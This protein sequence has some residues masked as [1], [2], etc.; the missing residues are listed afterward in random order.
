MRVQSDGFTN[1]EEEI[2]YWRIRMGGSID[3]KIPNGNS[4]D[5]KRSRRSRGLVRFSV[6][7]DVNAVPNKRSSAFWLVSSV[8]VLLIASTFF[9]N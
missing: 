9:D 8:T 5:G 4:A 3:R 1:G 7:S 2:E 6:I